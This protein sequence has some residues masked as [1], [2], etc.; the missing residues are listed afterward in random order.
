MHR[1]EL[2]LKQTLHTE[3]GSQLRPCALQLK[4]YFIRVNDIHYLA[5]NF[6][7]YICSEY[8]ECSKSMPLSLLY[9]IV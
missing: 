1:L 7:I 2:G 8:P 4:P 9:R 6:C 5:T 3:I